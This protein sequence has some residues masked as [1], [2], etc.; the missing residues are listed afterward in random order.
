MYT[1]NMLESLWC[2]EMSVTWSLPPTNPLPLPPMQWKVGRGLGSCVS[3]VKRG[4]I[5]TGWHINV[6]HVKNLRTHAVWVNGVWDWV[7]F[8]L[9]V[10]QLSLNGWDICGLKKGWDS[11]GK[12]SCFIWKY[13]QKVLVFRGV[14][15]LIIAWPQ[16]SVSLN[17]QP[18]EPSHPLAWD[19]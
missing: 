7:I 11:Y 17:S 10:G 8:G 3:T 2:H 5:N 16:V 15:F 18:S 9:R 13:T 6:H 14:P 12:V 4:G 19:T 1:S